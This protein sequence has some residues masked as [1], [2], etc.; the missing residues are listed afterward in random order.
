MS[1]SILPS[2][3]HERNLPMDI[4]EKIF[5]SVGKVK[6]M[7]LF[8]FN[9]KAAYTLDVIT[10]RVQVTSGTARR[11]LLNLEKM[12]LIKKRVQRIAKPETSSLKKKTKGPKAMV[13]M[14][15]DQFPFLS[16]LEM[17]LVNTVELL[18]GDLVRTLSKVGK[19]KLVIAAGIFTQ[20][21]ESR[22]D[23]LIVGDHLKK[24]AIQNILKNIESEVGKELRYAA[25]ETGDFNYRLSVYD[26]LVRDILDYPNERLLDKMGVK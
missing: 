6:M 24:R 13:W 10:D 16:Q 17:L 3:N 22:V 25:F 21:P 7:R 2:R 20:N 19:L 1:D 9:P 11:E 18:R 14:L 8:L 23:L 4:L 26:K 15:D 12:G 5:G